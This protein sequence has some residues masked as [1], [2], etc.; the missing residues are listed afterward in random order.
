MK[1]KRKWIL[2]VMAF[3]FV[4]GCLTGCGGPGDAD[5][6]VIA[7]HWYLR[8]MQ[9]GEHAYDMEALAHMVGSNADHKNEVAVILVV[10]EEGTFS[11]VEDLDKE[12]E[13]HG[14]WT[15]EED[16]WLFNIE[17]QNS[18][19]AFVE[20]DALVLHDTEST[21]ESRMIFGKGEE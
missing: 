14:T 3:I 12:Y 20:E 19:K 5:E 17:G 9:M 18:V 4:M 6:K 10:N 11:I 8:E 1:R 7:G 16:G 2:Q 13:E 15:E 21:I